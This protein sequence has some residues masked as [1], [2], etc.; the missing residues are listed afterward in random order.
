MAE[1][2]ASGYMVWYRDHKYSE[3]TWL[4]KWMKSLASLSQVADQHIQWKVANVANDVSE[5]RRIKDDGADKEKNLLAEMQESF[6]DFDHYL[7]M[8]DEVESELASWDDAAGNEDEGDE[9]E[10][11]DKQ[12][13]WIW[14]KKGF[15]ELKITAWTLRQV[16]EDELSFNT[17]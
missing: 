6:L 2:E 1:V 10:G 17:A 14:S 15:A 12:S 3:P 9:E 5:A 7:Q 11:P 8:V 13:V 16:L 4:K